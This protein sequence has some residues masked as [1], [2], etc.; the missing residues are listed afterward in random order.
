[1]PEGMKPSLIPWREAITTQGPPQ[2]IV[3]KP[4]KLKK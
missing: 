3:K 2:K 4:R 1:M